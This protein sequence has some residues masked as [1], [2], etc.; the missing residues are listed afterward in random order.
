[1][2]ARLRYVLVPRMRTAIRNVLVT[3]DYVYVDV[4]LP[5][6]YLLTPK[7]LRRLE[8]KFYLYGAVI[9]HGNEVRSFRVAIPKQVLEAHRVDL[10]M[11]K[12]YACK[13]VEEVLVEVISSE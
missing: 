3:R 7:T 6:P 1:M 12:Y 11:A 8:E 2:V 9:R 4:E 13:L 10:D 5:R